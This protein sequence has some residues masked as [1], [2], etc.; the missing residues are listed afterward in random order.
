MDNTTNMPM[1]MGITLFEILS[2]VIIFCFILYPRFNKW[3]EKELGRLVGSPR[4][5]INNKRYA[6]FSCLYL[7]TYA[8]F[9]FAL[10][11]FENL[12]L[13]SAMVGGD[14]NNSGLLSSMG[15]VFGEKSFVFALILVVLAL[16]IPVIDQVDQRWRKTLLTTARIPRESQDLTSELV[17]C[18]PLS[19]F[20]D[21]Q[22][23]K[24]R[25]K[26]QRLATLAHYTDQTVIDEDRCVLAKPLLVALYLLELNQSYRPSPIDRENLNEI[27]DRIKEITAVCA[28]LDSNEPQVINEYFSELES[29]THTLLELLA[30]NSVRLLPD[31]V[32][33]YATLSRQGFAL[34][35]NDNDK[36]DFVRP[37]LVCMLWI[38]FSSLLM[39][40]LSMQI[41]DLMSI[42]PP[43]NRATGEPSQYW[44]EIPRLISWSMGSAV[45]YIFAV[46]FGVFFN[47]ISSV[48]SIRRDYTTYFLAFVFATLGSSIYFTITKTAFLPGHLWLAISFG[49]LSTVAIESRNLDLVRHADVVR[50]AL[51]LSLYYAL[52]SGLL[53]IIIHLSFLPKLEF[54][55]VNMLC[56][57]ILGFMRGA[58]VSFFVAYV[59][60]DTER[61]HINKSKR[62]YPRITFRKV[63]DGKLANQRAEIAIKDLSEQ[64]ALIKVL[65]QKK[66][67]RGEPVFLNLGFTRVEGSIVW[68]S[69]Q[70]AGVK[71]VDNNLLLEP[72]A[73]FI[74]SK[75]REAY[76]F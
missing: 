56:F 18:L 11:N 67:T 27:E 66:P 52:L 60:L 76:S 75:M 31:E 74:G 30:K 73:Q 62:K 13:I 7:G 61:R 54:N 59:L 25:V 43:M 49:L 19:K 58:V 14:K 16:M 55:P 51:Y 69:H 32:H 15:Q 29:K 17:R 48:R 36:M 12:H 2:I 50:R 47:E 10:S 64:G 46:A 53:H 24:A 22:L 38:G 28:H 5:Y 21:S 34:D 26:F 3:P 41:L 63:V 35:F 70:S 40:M 71:F 57:F 6:F 1:P 9:A 4:D 68:V 39:L 72:I 23:A 20:S 42:R 65:S 44:L 8:L 45:S 33:R 37:A